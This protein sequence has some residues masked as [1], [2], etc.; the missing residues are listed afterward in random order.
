[1]PHEENGGQWAAVSKA[2]GADLEIVVEAAL[3]CDD[4]PSGTVSEA[5]DRLR[6]LVDTLAV[7][8]DIG[9]GGSEEAI[10]FYISHRADKASERLPIRVRPEDIQV[11]ARDIIALIRHDTTLINLLA[12]SDQYM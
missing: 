9:E 12:Q 3:R 7:F 5:A 6:L 4:S 11:P 2:Y 8:D 10:L 1:M